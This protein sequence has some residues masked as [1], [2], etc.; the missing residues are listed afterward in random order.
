MRCVLNSSTL[1]ALLTTVILAVGAIHAK[2]DGVP[3]SP[4][5]DVLTVTNGESTFSVSATEDQESD[6]VGKLFFISPKQLSSDNLVT[7]APLTYITDPNGK[8]S[9]IFGVF[10]ISKDGDSEGSQGFDYGSW[11]SSQSWSSWSNT[12]GCSI[13]D[14]NS[15]CQGNDKDKSAYVLGFISDPLGDAFKDF[16]TDKYWN[17]G[18]TKTLCVSGGLEAGPVTLSKYLK[19]DSGFTGIF[20]SPSLPPPDCSVAWRRWPSVCGSARRQPKF[21]ARI[22]RMVS[23]RAIYARTNRSGWWRKSKAQ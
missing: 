16:C 14:W 1:V 19:S 22:P 23:S 17:S 20:Q 3:T 9:D 13:W 10:K 12:S 8:I 21:S 18:K 2:A 7:I 15:N 5:S 11:F 6:N 4:P